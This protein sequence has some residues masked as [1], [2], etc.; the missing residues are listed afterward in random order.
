MFRPTHIAIA[1]SYRA[2]VYLFQV[3]LQS[4]L[5]N[6]VG[7]PCKFPLWGSHFHASWCPRPGDMAVLSQFFV[8]RRC[9]MG[10]TL[11]W[12]N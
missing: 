1:M 10:R 11:S 12:E 5:Y 9:E 6:S 4:K 2:V 3:L 8:C 7:L